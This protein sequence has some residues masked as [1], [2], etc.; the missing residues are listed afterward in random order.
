MPASFEIWSSNEL[1]GNGKQISTYKNNW[2]KN[3]KRRKM[4][5][6]V[7]RELDTRYSQ[8]LFVC[9]AAK[10]YKGASGFNFV[11]MF[12]ANSGAAQWSS[13]TALY[14]ACNGCPV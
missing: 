7:Q 12:P 13:V 4:C 9:A 11:R 10:R 5:T 1:N 3:T 14:A 6:T 8:Q 2:K